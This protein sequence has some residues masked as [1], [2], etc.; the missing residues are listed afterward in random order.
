MKGVLEPFFH[1]HSLYKKAISEGFKIDLECKKN[2]ISI[3]GGR[4]HSYEASILTDFIRTQLITE[5]KN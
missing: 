4:S 1:N 2:I 3:P 5:E